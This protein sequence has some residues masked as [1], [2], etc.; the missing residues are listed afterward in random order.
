MT[1]KWAPLAGWA[2]AM[3]AAYAWFR[4]TDWHPTNAQIILV[5]M[6]AVLFWLAAMVA[7]A[8][9]FGH[10]NLTL[11]TL[12][13]AILGLM[14]L[15]GTRYYG[16]LPDF[17]PWQSDLNSALWLGMAILLLWSVGRLAYDRRAG[18]E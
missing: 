1:E 15:F 7:W 5:V 10:R 13:V 18:D 4:W 8:P 12:A 14:H 11:I 2:A 17:Q 6:V 9:E 16:W 3:A